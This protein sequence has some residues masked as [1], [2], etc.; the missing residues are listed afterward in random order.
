[1]ITLVPADQLLHRQ[2]E[3]AHITKQNG[4]IGIIRLLQIG[5]C[6]CHWLYLDHFASM[7]K[8]RYIRMHKGTLFIAIRIQLHMYIHIYTR[9][10]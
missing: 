3:L 9:K 8:R 10:V 7:H 1:M 4:C 5:K 6:L 2:C